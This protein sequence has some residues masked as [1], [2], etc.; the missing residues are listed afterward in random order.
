MEKVL[1]TGANGFIG[2]HLVRELLDRGYE[3]S[4]LVRPTS[5]V[6]SLEGLP[7]RLFL[8]DVR[9]PETLVAPLQGVH[10][11]YHLA[12]KLMVNS[13]EDFLQT[14]TE[15]TKHM[16]EA[17]KKYAADSLK[18]FLLVSSQ[19]GAGPSTDT[20][21]LDETAP[22]KPVSWYGQSKKEAEEAA[23]SSGLPVTIVRPS[24]VYGEREMDISQVFPLVE[25]HLQPQ[26][27]VQT[28]YTVMGYVGDLVRGMIAAAESDNTVG[29]TYFLNHP[30][31]LTAKQ[32]V[33]TTANAMGKPWGLVFPVP[34]ILIQLGGPLG[35]LIY[36]F[37]RSRPPMTRDK[38]REVAQRFWVASPARAKQDF[39]WEAEHDLMQGMQITTQYYLDEQR[40][41]RA[42]PLEKQPMLWFKY[43]VCAAI[44]GSL[45]EMT[46]ALGQFYTFHPWWVSYIVALGAFGVGLGTAAMLLRKQSDLLQFIVGTILAGG[47]EVWNELGVL[48]FGSWTFAPGWPFGITDPWIR[49]TVL[50]CAGGVFILV[51]NFL[52]RLLYQRRLRLG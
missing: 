22:M 33:Q 49:A 25:N 42:M 7:V 38:A 8:G 10:Y 50:G 27:G 13:R 21:P 36:E 24:A 17:A 39:G 11:V 4:G 15:G 3:V 6:R 20:T 35:E 34:I 44:V 1:V 41:L 12:A 26:L 52:V 43:I 32:I 37:T 29:K 47:A 16:L 18:R 30:Q 28:K 46:S 31:V 14:N 2:S 45:I 40:Q 51:V 9:E 19:A 23:H 5:D 48:S